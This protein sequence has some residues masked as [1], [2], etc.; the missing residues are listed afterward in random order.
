M[1]ASL[2]K[3]FS[4]ISSH[5]LQHNIDQTR[6]SSQKI[7]SEIRWPH[8]AWRIG[9]SHVH[10]LYSISLNVFWKIKI[11]KDRRLSLARNSPLVSLSP[12]ELL[13][14]TLLN[15]QQQ[16]PVSER[17]RVGNLRNLLQS[18]QNSSLILP[19]YSQLWR[20]SSQR[21][22]Q[23]VQRVMFQLILPEPLW[24]GIWIGRTRKLHQK[25]HQSLD[26]DI[27]QGHRI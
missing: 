2:K 16:V 8:V 20:L 5:W 14:P 25:L 4:F 18:V 21:C 13:L 26:L 12:L 10:T 24:W 27:Q 6:L 22:S 11:T 1:L 9:L 3:S 23:R 19:T 7:D 15:H 17:I